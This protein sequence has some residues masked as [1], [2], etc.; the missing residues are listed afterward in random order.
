M[1]GQSIHFKVVERLVGEMNGLGYIEIR[2][3]VS[4]EKHVRAMNTPLNP[5]FI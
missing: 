2:H 4:S 1:S 3:L 5:S